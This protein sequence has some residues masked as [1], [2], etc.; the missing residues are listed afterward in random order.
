MTIIS[1]EL[2][3]RNVFIEFTNQFA[4]MY[5]KWLASYF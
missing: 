4:R 2:K 5:K 3:Q 1:K